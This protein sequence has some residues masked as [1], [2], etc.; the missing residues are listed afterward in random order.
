MPVTRKSNNRIKAITGRQRRNLG[1]VS[2]D[3]L[4]QRAANWRRKAILAKRKLGGV[5]DLHIEMM[6]GMTKEK[7]KL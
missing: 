3:E 2:A 6:E 5:S 1:G 4:R 7:Y